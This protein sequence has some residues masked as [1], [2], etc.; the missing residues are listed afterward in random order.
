MEK[1][2]NQQKIDLSLVKPS[3]ILTF[4]LLR[5]SALKITA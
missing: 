1:Q 2:R 4:P 3:R 5:V